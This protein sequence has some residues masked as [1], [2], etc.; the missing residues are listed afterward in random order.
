MARTRDLVALS[1][2][3]VAP[4]AAIL[5]SQALL[6]AEPES[7]PAP[8]TEPAPVV[9]PAPAPSP[10]P[11]P[12]V[13]SAPEVTPAPV[14][15]P[16][17]PVAAPTSGRDPAEA[18]LLYKDALVLDTHADI[19]WASGRAAIT[20]EHSHLLATRSVRWDRL[21]APVR[22]LEGATVVV[23]DS[24]GSTCI[25]TVDAARLHLERS[26]DIYGEFADES[27]ESWLP[28]TSKSAVRDLVKSM[29]AAAD[30]LLLLGAQA[31]EDGRA[32]EG[33]WAR[34]ADL[35]APIVFGRRTPPEAERDALSEEA[36]AVVRAQPEFVALAAEHARHVEQLDAGSR[37]DEPDWDTFVAT[38]FRVEL[39]HELGG[40]RRYVSVELRL[41]DPM[42]C[43]D[44]FV[45]SLALL[46]EQRG[47]RL[48]RVDQESWY[49]LAALMDLDRDGV[50]EGVSR[51]GDHTALRADDRSAASVRD[52][53]FIPFIGCPC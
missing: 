12:V 20:A 15:A 38:N 39:W 7:V 41:R 43:S 6:P 10:A 45:G 44:D 48:V 16:E 42:P 18:M 36:L 27:H 32:C 31:S 21:P 51:D 25:T 40:P 49:D 50:L 30:D 3:L 46:L 28:P 13:A 19:A 23:Y 11:E 35:P 37:D 33:L 8:V 34:R 52:E 29:F 5:V 1:A 14:T 53:F 2:I 47:D 17:P 24:D 4:L 22:G 9:A 26:G